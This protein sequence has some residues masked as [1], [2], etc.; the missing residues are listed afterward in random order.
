MYSIVSYHEVSPVA[1]Y[2]RLVADSSQ[3][4]AVKL[5]T[6]RAGDRAANAGLSHTRGSHKTQ[7]GTL[8]GTLELPDSQIL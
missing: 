1:T 5:S 3:G 4:N 6:Q 8:K 2:V 7:Y